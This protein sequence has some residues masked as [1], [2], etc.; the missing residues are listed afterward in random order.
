MQK[1]DHFVYALCIITLIVIVKSILAKSET[2][3]SGM[4]DSEDMEEVHR[5]QKPSEERKEKPSL[6]SPL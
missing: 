4:E 3:K 2:R 5:N 6:L 1:Y